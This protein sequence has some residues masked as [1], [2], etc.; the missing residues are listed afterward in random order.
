MYNIN[1]VTTEE[2]LK[3]IKDLFIID[4]NL[5][6]CALSLKNND[7]AKSVFEMRDVRKDISDFLR[8]WNFMQ[9]T[10]RFF[11][12]T[13]MINDKNTREKVKIKLYEEITT[14]YKVIEK[15]NTAIENSNYGSAAICINDLLDTIEYIMN[16]LVEYNRD[17]F[18]D[19]VF[20]RIP[21]DQMNRII[22]DYKKNPDNFYDD[23]YRSSSEPAP[24]SDT[25]Y[26]LMQ[27]M[28]SICIQYPF[29]KAE[30]KEKFFVYVE[31]ANKNSK[32]YKG[33][34]IALPSHEVHPVL[35]KIR[36]KAQ[37]LKIN[38]SFSKLTNFNIKKMQ[39]TQI[40]IKI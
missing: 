9:C 13:V 37:S 3:I 29:N 16:S 20:N 4:S 5:K 7:I 14:Y 18:W 34:N 21:E 10:Y 23:N 1:H 25:W 39:W 35:V 17:I 15:F 28:N 2:Q 30:N 33:F 11:I 31:F 19:F 32:V 8:N 27:F 38:V 26:E 22:K 36:D 6:I 24:K 40:L 12:D